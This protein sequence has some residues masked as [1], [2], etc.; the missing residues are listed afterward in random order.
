MHHPQDRALRSYTVTVF[1]QHCPGVETLTDNRGVSIIAV[2][3]AS[4]EHLEANSLNSV[5]RS[6]A[7]TRGCPHSSFMAVPRS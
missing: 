7:E 3:D 4:A 1:G 2:T 6:A 5:A